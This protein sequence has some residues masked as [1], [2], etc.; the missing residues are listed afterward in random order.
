MTGIR[1]KLRNPVFQIDYPQGFKEALAESSNWKAEIEF[2]GNDNLK[3]S[4]I[5]SGGQILQDE[6]RIP[7]PRSIQRHQRRKHFRLEAPDGMTLAFNVKANV[8]KEK[9]ID[10]SLGGAMIALAYP[11]DKDPN[12][13]PFRIGDV[14]QDVELVFPSETGDHRI[15]IKKAAVVR[16][17]D[18]TSGPQKYCGLQFIEIKKT[19]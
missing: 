14:L 11:E 7:F 17:E 2:T 18:G 3:Y 12:G 1:K 10:V 4:F 19:R 6:I 5:A 9:V 16:I 13:L 15:D 8:C